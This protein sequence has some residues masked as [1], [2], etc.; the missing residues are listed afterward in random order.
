MYNKK[1]F[2]LVNDEK[3]MEQMTDSIKIYKPTSVAD[4]F[5]GILKI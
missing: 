2:A 5:G 3:H 4:I 1:L